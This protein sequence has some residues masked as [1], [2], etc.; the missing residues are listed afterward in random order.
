MPFRRVLV[1]A[2]LTA[3]SA[4][5]DTEQIQPYVHRDSE[6][7][8]SPASVS[9]REIKF[10]IDL[11]RRRCMLEKRGSPPIYQVEVNTDGVIYVHCGPHYGVADA[12]GAL[13]FTVERKDRVWR[14]T[15][16]Q[17]YNPGSSSERVIVT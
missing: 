2:T 7:G 5:A 13:I 9:D 17:Q 4:C 11:V 12:A 15:N 1:V 10:A 14:I 3:L 8:V 6:A 16:M